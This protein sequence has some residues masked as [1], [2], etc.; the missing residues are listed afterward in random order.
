MR[1]GSSE[2]EPDSTAANL[3]QTREIEGVLKQEIERQVSLSRYKL[4]RLDTGDSTLQRKPWLSQMARDHRDD[5]DRAL[6]RVIASQDS[7]PKPRPKDIV[8]FVVDSTGVQHILFVQGFGSSMTT[9]EFFGKALGE[10]VSRAVGGAIG[11]AIFGR[12][13]WDTAVETDESSLRSNFFLEARLVDVA[14]GQILWH[15]S[16]ASEVRV[17]GYESGY[18]PRKQRDLRAACESLLAP[19]VQAPI[20]RR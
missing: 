2:P 6:L 1:A 12:H 14:D 19:L 7:A 5:P 13:N 9:G 20:G 17:Q 16:V 15:N 3:Q 10:E 18:D 8:D 4:R 11:K